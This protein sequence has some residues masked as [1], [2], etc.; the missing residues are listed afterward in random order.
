MGHV[1]FLRGRVEET[2]DI[3]GRLLV[4]FDG[5][6]GLC[7][8]SVR[9]LMRRDLQDRMR[10]AALDSAKVAG[11]LE[12]HSLSGLELA[13]GTL[14]VVRDTGKATESVLQRSDAVVALLNELPQP[15]PWVG[16][17][18]KWIPRPMRDY[19]YRLVARWRHRIWGRLESCPLPTAEDKK[20][21]L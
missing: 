11:L 17:A 15:W 6:C 19:G 16:S 4:V 12:W 18:L 7:I 21:F 2:I 14:L 3:G 8:G 10:F 20:R 1:V 13:T 9:W 5:H